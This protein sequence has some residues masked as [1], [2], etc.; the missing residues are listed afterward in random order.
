MRIET[1]LTG[2]LEAHKLHR[3]YID[4][5]TQ[6]FQPLSHRIALHQNDANRPILV[7]IHGSQG[8]GKTTL[9][10][11][12]A[13]LLEQ[14]HHRN[15]IALSI[16]D[17]YLTL[18]ERQQLA[19]NIHPLL[20]TR[21]VPGTHDMQ[22][23]LDTLQQLLHFNKAVQIPRFNKARDD[24][25][26]TTQWLKLDKPVDVIILEGWCLGCEPQSN[27]ELRTPVN[28][29]ERKRDID[30]RWR[31]YVNQQ[32]EQRYLELNKLADIWVMLK[33]PSF[34]C[35][36][37]WRLEQEQKLADQH[38]QESNIMNAD[39]IAEFIQFYQRITEHC[40]VILPPKMHFLFEL[41]RGRQIMRVTEPKTLA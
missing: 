6:W 2:F 34:D 29:L 37:E 11:V 32:I 39:Q 36:Y 22:L 23:T 17:F 20:A 26:A 25:F 30:G 10:A 41:G 13:L 15:A 38:K 28:E 8:S 1:L 5:A 21:G 27:D 3:T 4:I 18:A 33:A 24:R 40:L 16:D 35:V 12:L 31:Q 14:L 19:K 7:A 9:A